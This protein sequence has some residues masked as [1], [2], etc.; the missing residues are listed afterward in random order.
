MKLSKEQRDKV[1]VELSQPWGSADLICDGFRIALRVEC[2]KGMTYRVM[3]YVN[4]Y[5]KGA[6]VFPKNECPESRFL[7]K[8]EHLACPAKNRLE[9]EKIL[10][11]RSVAK[12]PYYS[13]KI[14]FYWPDWSSG[15]AAL[16]HLCKVCE[17]V[18]V[19]DPQ[20]SA[21]KPE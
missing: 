14:T 18:Q 7:R 6:W 1:I 12:D 17:S 21:V 10:G 20:T 9:M 5:Y 15:K 11:K 8:A 4:G 2:F 3:T 19:A 16:S 13:K